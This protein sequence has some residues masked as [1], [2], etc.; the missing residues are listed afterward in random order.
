MKTFEITIKPLSGFGTPL[1]GDTL[2]GHICWQ[3]AYDEGLFGMSINKLLADYAANPFMVISSAYPKLDDGYA[4]KRPDIP[5]D[6]LFNFSGNNTEDIIARRKEFKG[7]RW[8]YVKNGQRI[9]SLK[10]NGL[11][12]SDEQLFKKLSETKDTETLRQLKKRG[13]KS[14][15]SDYTQPHNTINRLTGTTG[16]GQFTPYSVDQTVYMPDAE[17][18][19]F[20]GLRE[21]IADEQFIK[22][23]KQISESGFGKD[24]STGLGR[25]KVEGHREIDLFA[26]GS[27]TPDACYTLAPAVPERDAFSRMS[28]TP[29]TRFGRHGDILANRV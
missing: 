14:F 27:K 5:L 8:M 28:F 21:D 18:V 3:A 9:T 19:V 20:A 23:L 11:Y 12:Y 17:L 1:K 24:A 15:I 26:I 2:F 13:V 6:M 22:A 16:E 25:F 7:R 4:L 10:S 29:F